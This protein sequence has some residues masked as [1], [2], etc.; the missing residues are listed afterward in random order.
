ME[1][2]EI[3]FV[4]GIFFKPKHEKAPDWVLG[5]LSLKRAELIEYLN[6]KSDEWVNCQVL[7]SKKDKPYIIVDTFKPEKKEITDTISNDI[8]EDDSLPF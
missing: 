5:N 7:M 4:K 8:V 6:S 1:K 2:K 3:E